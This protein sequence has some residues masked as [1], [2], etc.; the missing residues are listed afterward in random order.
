[1][2]LIILV[3]GR[4]VLMKRNSSANA[5][6]DCSG[7]LAT[8]TKKCK[9]DDVIS[10]DSDLNSTDHATISH[11]PRDEVRWDLSNVNVKSYRK[12]LFQKLFGSTYIPSSYANL[13]P[14]NISFTLVPTSSIV[15]CQKSELDFPNHVYRM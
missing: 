3:I 4:I 15:P 7:G 9:T 10:L 1:M 6:L 13:D 5:K 2:L 14:D 12:H 8:S 11:M